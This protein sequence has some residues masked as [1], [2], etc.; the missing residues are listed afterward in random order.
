MIDYL[1]RSVF[2]KGIEN[3]PRFLKDLL[4]I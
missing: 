1:L 2:F 3:I 4:E